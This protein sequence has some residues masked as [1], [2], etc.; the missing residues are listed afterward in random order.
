MAVHEHIA[1]LACNRGL[2][3]VDI[4]NPQ[5]PRVWS[6]GQV[7]GPF[8]SIAV[9]GSFAYLVD[10][11][12]WNLTIVDVSDP[13]NP[14]QVGYFSAKEVPGNV[15]QFGISPMFSEVR[16]C[17]NRLCLAARQDG[18]VILDVSNPVQPTFAGHFDTSAA[19]GLA[20]R[21][22]MVYLV[23]DMDGVYMLDISTPDRPSQVG[24]LPTVVG[25]FELSVH[26]F[27]ER[28]V[29]VQDNL[30]FVTDPAYGLT[31]VD[32]SSGAPLRVGRYQTPLPDLLVAVR[33]EG[34]Y[35]YVVGR[36]GGFRVVDVSDPTTPHEVYYDDKRK[37]LYLQDPS[38]LVVEGGYAYVSD[39]NY[40]LRIYDVSD[41]RNPVEV[42]AVHDPT[43]SDGANDIVLYGQVA[44][45]SGSGGPD[46]FYPG[47][48][49]WVVDVSDPTQPKAVEF[50]D[51]P[52]EHWRLALYDHYLYAMDGTIDDKQP[53]PLSLR[54]F[55][56]TDPFKPVEITKIP[57]PEAERGNLTAILTDQRYLYLNILGTPPTLK[58]YDLTNPTQPVEVA[59]HI[60]KSAGY[61]ALEKEGNI[62]LLSPAIAYDVSDPKNL[63][64]VGHAPDMLD[65]WAVDMVGDL[66]FAVAPFHGLYIFRRIP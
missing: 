14:R 57:I 20:S 26:E 10:T 53:E 51:V 54:I 13:S 52:N 7:K 19:S 64:Y 47:N 55:D 36:N 12:K 15:S 35:A 45:L 32:V 4:A 44:Y 66:V 46:A 41:P 34:K 29:A 1:Y 38:G 9:I 40:P 60:A 6:M 65:I 39:S 33:V 21:G 37:D 50:V 49:L 23:D 8:I 2:F 42:G 3:I 48:G 16:A 30:V 5:Q 18:L 59:S 62:L 27:G 43:A 31:L 11:T 22:N 28:G 25:E 24:M 56:L 17:G 61:P 63:V 58:V